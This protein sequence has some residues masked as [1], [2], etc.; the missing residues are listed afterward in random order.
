LSTNAALSPNIETDGDLDQLIYDALVAIQDASQKSAKRD[1]LAHLPNNSVRQQQGQDTRST[2]YLPTYLDS[3]KKY[4]SPQKST[5]SIQSTSLQRRLQ[6]QDF[7][8]NS[9]GDSTS[10]Y[11]DNRSEDT[12][13]PNTY[14]SSSRSRSFEDAAAGGE[15]NESSNPWLSDSS[16]LDS[17]KRSEVRRNVNNPTYN[18][19]SYE[20]DSRTIS[21]TRTPEVSASMT[22]YSLKFEEPW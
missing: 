18:G 10:R 14:A 2:Q 6:N 1:R 7:Q 13:S 19:A 15:F 20:L 22:P 9:R 8:P 11:A 21:A 3:P 4:P 5:S 12:R 16:G 17:V